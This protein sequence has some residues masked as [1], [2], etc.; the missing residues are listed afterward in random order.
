MKFYYLNWSSWAAAMEY[1]GLAH[2]VTRCADFSD[3]DQLIFKLPAFI[4]SNTS[5]ILQHI[6]WNLW[7]TI[8][9]LNGEFKWIVHPK[10]EIAINYIPSCPSRL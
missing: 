9:S 2:S 1:K 8:E 3:S 6:T 10:M 5:A 4:F 7:L